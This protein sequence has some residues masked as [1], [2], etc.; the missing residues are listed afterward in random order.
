MAVLS[1]LGRFVARTRAARVG[2]VHASGAIIKQKV[3]MN[4]DT[5][6]WDH[7]ELEDLF[8]WLQRVLQ[9]YAENPQ[10]QECLGLAGD[11]LA[12]IRLG[13]DAVGRDDVV[14]LCEEMRRVVTALAEERIE[15]TPEGAELLVRSALRLSGPVGLTAAGPEQLARVLLP[16]VNDLRQL[17]GAGALMTP[18][19][20]MAPSSAPV[21]RPP[22]VSSDSPRLGAGAV[23]VQSLH[24]TRK[25]FQRGLLE[26]LQG[27]DME[28]ATR[29]LAEIST[30][31]AQSLPAGDL[32]ELFRLAARLAVALGQG[33]DGATDSAKPLLGRVDRQLGNALRQAESAL[34]IGHDPAAEVFAVDQDLTGMIEAALRTPETPMVDAT[35]SA[36]AAMPVA[37][38]G[39]RPGAPVEPR[40][41]DEPSMETGPRRSDSGE[42]RLEPSIAGSVQGAGISRPMVREADRNSG[43]PGGPEGRHLA[44]LV[45]DRE[46]LD[47]RVL[48]PGA[49]APQ[50]E[51][52][53]VLDAVVGDLR[54]T[55]VGRHWAPGNTAAIASLGD[56]FRALHEHARD[57]APRLGEFARILE[58]FV[59]ESRTASNG[60]HAEAAQVIEDAVNVL[61]GLLNEVRSGGVPDTPVADI[62]LRVEA[63]I[64]EGF[65][66]PVMEPE[67]A[68]SQ[69]ED[70]D[71]LARMRRQGGAEMARLAAAF[72][73]LD[74]D[75]EQA[76]ADTDNTLPP[77]EAALKTA[78]VRTSE[79]ASWHPRVV[80]ALTQVAGHTRML[81]QILARL[82]SGL[83]VEIG[84]G[85]PEAGGEP[86]ASGGDLGQVLE[87][88]ERL[89]LAIGTAVG[90][91]SAALLQQHRAIKELQDRLSAD[92]RVGDQDVP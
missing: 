51:R 75:A 74:G 48:P 15:R 55:S 91:A 23:W 14:Q 27:R 45:Y 49:Q 4:M 46:V 13:L 38:G 34:V 79:V 12:Q 36:H 86:A 16:L 19:I 50:P 64:E 3:R 2:S 1:G 28:G 70:S 84:I 10:C 85:E 39:Q 72:A 82:R 42:A 29:R 61:P 31:I 80:D 65:E 5:G 67:S 41:V 37:R 90:N 56:G 58:H 53:A 77:A 8:F 73:A 68:G 20:V 76:S 89:H 7:G 30:A 63:I 25:R 40:P 43:W 33:T 69:V 87:E 17:R 54:N 52:I 9:K 32:A 81:E 71:K 21:P 83:L 88:L 66:D 60:I 47:E 44:P 57:V 22:S 62:V 24:Q 6:T 59:A 26:L 35:L 78:L 92:A 11:G 18:A